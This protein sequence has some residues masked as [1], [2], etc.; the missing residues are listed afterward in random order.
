[1]TK[2]MYIAGKVTGQNRTDCLM[3]FQ[4]AENH[5]RMMGFEPVNPMKIVPEGT[6]WSLAMRICLKSLLTCEAIMVLPDY[7]D[8]RGATMEVEVAR[9]TGIEIIAK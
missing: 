7:M 9:A 3:K 1:M 5:A 8:S 2:R 4:A 6:T